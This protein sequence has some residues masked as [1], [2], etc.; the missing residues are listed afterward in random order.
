MGVMPV[1]DDRVLPDELVKALIATG[2]WQRA[3]FTVG[4]PSHRCVDAPTK[5]TDHFNGSMFQRTVRQGL[6]LDL[7]NEKG[8]PAFLGDNAFNIYCG[9]LFG[10]PQLLQPPGSPPIAWD[11][12]CGP[13]RGPQC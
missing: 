5:E 2:Q 3:N 1:K 7:P 13:R 12:R 4:P 6:R 11:G 10:K 8:A 9:S